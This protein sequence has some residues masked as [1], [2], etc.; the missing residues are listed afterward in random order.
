MAPTTE[1]WGW[2]GAYAPGNHTC[3]GDGDFLAP[4]TFLVPFGELGR[5]LVA[6][7]ALKRPSTSLPVFTEHW[8]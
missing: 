4:A 5:P 1:P 7:L 3:R 8:K 6:S 2:G